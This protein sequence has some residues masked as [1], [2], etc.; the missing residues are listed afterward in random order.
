MSTMNTNRRGSDR[1]GREARAKLSEA[2]ARRAGGDHALTV[3]KRKARSAAKLADAHK[4][5]RRNRIGRQHIRRALDEIRG[6]APVIGTLLVG[7]GVACFAS[8]Y[9]LWLQLSYLLGVSPSS[10]LGMAM[11]VA[12]ASAM[13]VT[14]IAWD[15]AIEGPSHARR[16]WLPAVFASTAGCALALVG[17]YLAWEGGPLRE[18]AVSA[19]RAIRLGDTAALDHIDRSAVP[20]FVALFAVFINL[21]GAAMFTIG[22]HALS[23]S[24]RY[25]FLRLRLLLA[26]LYGAVLS[27]IT[28]RRRVVD[29]ANAEELKALPKWLELLEQ[30]IK[31]ASAVGLSELEPAPQASPPSPTDLLDDL[32]LAEATRRSTLRSGAPN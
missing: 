21:S 20:A 19:R 24:R 31:A 18:I 6:A 10:R 14:K 17:L 26:G 27:A 32:A 13:L 28:R 25:A 3:K 2:K 11:G 23:D 12:A 22:C 5:E 9:A 4:R 16:S 7:A 8:E 30:E 1:P 29:T 15:R